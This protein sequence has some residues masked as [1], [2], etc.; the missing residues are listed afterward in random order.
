VKLRAGVA[1]DAE[2]IARLVASF[3][4]EITNHPDGVGAEEYLASVSEQS[5]RGYLESS[6]YAFLM[7]EDGNSLV[8]FI[9]LRDVTHVFHMFVARENQR[10]GVARL[11]WNEA[12]SQALLRSSASTFTVNSSLNAVPVYRAFGFK[13]SGAVRSVHGIAFLPMQLAVVRE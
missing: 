9:A 7:A 2:A 10:K 3:Q 8:G 1:T 5:E 11:L 6:R 12:R 4:R 13:A